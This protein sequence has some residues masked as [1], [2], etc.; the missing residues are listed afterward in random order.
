MTANETK[1]AGKASLVALRA[2]GSA[3]NEDGEDERIKSGAETFLLILY[4]LE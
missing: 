2:C 3:C 1:R 4:D